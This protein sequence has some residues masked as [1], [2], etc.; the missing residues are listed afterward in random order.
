MILSDL[1]IPRGFYISLQP[2]HAPNRS[3]LLTNVIYYQNILSKFIHCAEDKELDAKARVSFQGSSLQVNMGVN[4]VVLG[5]VSVQILRFP[6]ESKDSSHRPLSCA[7][8]PLCVVKI[9]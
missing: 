4:I 7:L 2:Y 1:W 6:H 3:R 9:A 5:Q 8:R